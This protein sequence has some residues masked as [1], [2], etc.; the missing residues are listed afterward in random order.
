MT[1]RSHGTIV[2]LL[3]VAVLLLLVERVRSPA[4]LRPRSDD[5]ARSR[6]PDGAVRVRGGV[7]AS[8]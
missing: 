1:G 3:L 8:P 4:F 5:L 6:R 2:L 7:G